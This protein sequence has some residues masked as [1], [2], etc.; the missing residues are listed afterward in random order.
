MGEGT[1]ARTQQDVNL[2][3]SDILDN[4]SDLRVTHVF[5]IQML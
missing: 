3:M 1:T 5:Q 2:P 4:Q